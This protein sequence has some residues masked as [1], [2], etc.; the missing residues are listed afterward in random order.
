MLQRKHLT[1]TYLDHA[2]PET[3]NAPLM[4]MLHGYGSNEKDLVQL[5][6]ILDERVRYISARAPH[7]LDFGMFGWFPIEFTANGII[8]DYDAAE[9]ARR[10]LITFIGEIIAEYRPQGN[11]V[12]LMG[13]SQGSVMSY[14][15]AF[16]RP[17]LLHGVIACSGQLPR[18]DSVPENSKHALRQLPFLVVHGV[19]DDVLPI[20]KGAESNR[21]LKGMVTDLTYQEFPMAHE[22]SPAALKLVSEWLQERLARL[23]G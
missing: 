13:F 18:Q 6:P 20:E 17:E 12:F 1:L 11:R 7:S 16:E 10:Q 3:E 9:E 14:L 23:E 22:I 5:G 21:F 19:F 2:P 15:A 8:V 4:I